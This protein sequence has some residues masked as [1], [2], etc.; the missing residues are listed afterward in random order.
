MQFY[1]VRF[2]EVEVGGFYL[3]FTEEDGKVAHERITNRG[4]ILKS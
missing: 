1:V 3:T 4:G 2:S